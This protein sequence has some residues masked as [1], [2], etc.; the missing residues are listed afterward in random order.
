MTKVH[1]F[2]WFSTNE[3]PLSSKHDFGFSK[4]NTWWANKE[5]FHISKFHYKKDMPL[6]R[7]NEDIQFPLLCF[8]FSSWPVAVQH[9]CSPIG[10]KDLESDER[11]TDPGQTL[12][13]AATQVCGLGVCVCVG[14]CVEDILT[15]KH[16]RAAGSDHRIPQGLYSCPWLQFASAQWP[17]LVSF[18]RDVSVVV[19]SKA[20][21]ITE[22][23]LLN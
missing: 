10:Q 17:S 12:P 1:F 22:L 11:D 7:S 15:H 18:S 8:V 21:L 9:S 16:T 23:I 13:Q 3:F 5:K 6:Y 2:T 20:A 14:V 19:S 4:L